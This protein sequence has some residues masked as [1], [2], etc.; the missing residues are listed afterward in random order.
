MVRLYLFLFTKELRRI[1]LIRKVKIILLSFKG[2]CMFN[3][4]DYFFNFKINKFLMCLGRVLVVYEF[5]VII[6]N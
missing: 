2:Y 6:V 5:F 3:G 1:I 4:I